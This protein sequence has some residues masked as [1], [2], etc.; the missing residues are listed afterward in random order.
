MSFRFIE[1]HRDAD[2]VR[3][4]CAVLEVSPAGY[5]AWRDRPVSERTKSNASLLAAIRQV[6][7][8]VVADRATHVHVAFGRPRRSGNVPQPGRR[9]VETGLTIGEGAHDSE[10]V[11]QGGVLSPLLSNIMLH[12]FDAWLEAKYLS[13]KARKDRWAWNFGIKLGRPIALRENR[14]WKPA[15]AYCRYA[16]DF[17]VIV[18]GTKAQAEEIHQE[19]RAFWKAS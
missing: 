18:K 3:L 8:R 1:D 12:E 15:V 7:Q 5:Y 16:D 14:Q 6:H 10:G 13:D 17:V 19:C 9:Q 4:I 11:P 2:P